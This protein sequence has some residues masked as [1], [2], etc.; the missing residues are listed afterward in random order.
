V[1]TARARKVEAAMRVREN[2]RHE[3]YCISGHTDGFLMSVCGAFPDVTVSKRKTNQETRPVC[4][5]CDTWSLHV[6]E[7]TV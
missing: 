3:A 2:Q 7:A 1:N 6:C 5:K 4:G